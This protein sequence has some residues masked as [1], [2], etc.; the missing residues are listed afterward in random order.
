MKSA[1]G[2]VAFIGLAAASIL[3]CSRARDNTARAP[4][5]TGFPSEQ[6]RTVA[7]RR[8]E[9]R[10]EASRAEARQPRAIGGGPA[11]GD[12]RFTPTLR[13]IA[14]AFCDRAM[15]CGD[16]GPNEKY[17][18]RDD[19]VEKVKEEKRGY[20]DADQCSLGI[21]Q[22]GLGQCTRAIADDDCGNKLDSI[23]DLRSCKTSNVCLR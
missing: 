18:S 6:D 8:A 1:V 20:I 16:V 19:C 2:R 11:D 9:R 22:T 15:R 4:V 17:A 5:S 7:E 10:Y 21:S 13:K 12:R 3:S 14:A 23:S